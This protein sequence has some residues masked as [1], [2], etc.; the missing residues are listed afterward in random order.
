MT[1]AGHIRTRLANGEITEST[2]NKRYAK[3]EERLKELGG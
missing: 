2:C 1:F 3:W